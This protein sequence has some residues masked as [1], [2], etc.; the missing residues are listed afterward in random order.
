MKKPR[1]NETGKTCEDTRDE[2]RFN[3]AV[4]NKKSLQLRYNPKLQTFNLSGTKYSSSSLVPLRI[5]NQFKSV[6]GLS[7]HWETPT[8]KLITP[9]DIGS[10]GSASPVTSK[11]VG[12]PSSS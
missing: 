10:P 7:V 2:P 5:T 9:P 11:S 6:A 4:R 12:F 8:L 1:N 3:G